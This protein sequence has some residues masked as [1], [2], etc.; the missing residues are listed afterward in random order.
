[1]F[2]HFI[3]WIN[4]SSDLKTF[5]NSSALNSK[6]F[7]QSLKKIQVSSLVFSFCVFTS[8]FVQSRNCYLFLWK[9]QLTLQNLI[10]GAKPSC[11]QLS[12]SLSSPTKKNIFLSNWVKKMKSLITIIFLTPDTFWNRNVKILIALSI[13]SWFVS[14]P[15]NVAVFF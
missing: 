4:C 12:N 3:A 10:A 1:M 13:C 6:C 5:S 15:A 11:Q 7:S 9:N 8:S 2:W 14:H